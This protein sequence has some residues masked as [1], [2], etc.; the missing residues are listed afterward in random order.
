MKSMKNLIVRLVRE[1]EGAAA[2][3]Y[4]I[5]AALIASAV[6]LA[7]AAFDLDGIFTDVSTHIKGKISAAVN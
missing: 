4:A 1:E 3:E 2:T 7:V 6:A 5:L